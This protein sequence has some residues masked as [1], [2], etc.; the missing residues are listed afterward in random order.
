MPSKTAIVRQTNMLRQNQLIAIE[1]CLD[2]LQSYTKE[3][4]IAACIKMHFDRKF[5]GAWNCI[6]GRSYGAGITHMDGGFI[7]VEVTPVFITIFRI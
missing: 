6:L 4:D 3:K 7:L 5:G 2:S 1:I